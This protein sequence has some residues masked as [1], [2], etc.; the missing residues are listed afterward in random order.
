[1]SWASLN[2]I[3]FSSVSEISNQFLLNKKFIC[4]DS[5][6][7][8]NHKLI[9]AGILTVRGL[10]D[11]N[12]NFKGL[13][14]P[15]HLHLSQIDHFL[16]VSL[17]DAI[18]EECRKQLKANETMTSLDAH[19]IDLDSFS[20]HFKGKKINTDK[21]Q[22]KLLYEMFS[23]QISSEP[24]TRKKYNKMFNTETFQLDWER[25]YSLPF[26][27][28]LDTKSREFQYKVLLRICYTVDRTLDH[29]S[30]QFYPGIYVALVSLTFSVSTC[31]TEHSFSGIKRLKT[32]PRSTMSDKWLS[33]LAILHI[34]KHKTVDINKVVSEFF[35]CKERRFTFFL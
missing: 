29:T 14:F 16:L 32:P 25:V 20:L 24:M 30:P 1:M 3:N 23:T 6:S 31:A 8:Y 34:H 9:D 17:V 2:S 26:Q 18:P 15:C 4:I 11:S 12:R 19:H 33:S 13:S 27:I 5:R 35:Q 10:F 21:I 7:V 22:S 28:T